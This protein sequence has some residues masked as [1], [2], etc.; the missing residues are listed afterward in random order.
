MRFSRHARNNMRLYGIT[1]E[2]VELI[3]SMSHHR[4][5]EGEYLIAYRHFVRRFGDDP[6][7][8]VYVIEDEPVIVS[9]Y[10]LKRSYRR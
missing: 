9:V 7:K 8:V 1:A 10:P 6:V 5:Q 2:D 4:D 3:L